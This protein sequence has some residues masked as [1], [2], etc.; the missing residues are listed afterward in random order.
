MSKLSIIDAKQFEKLLFEL[1]FKAVRQKAVTF[2]TDILTGAILF[3]R[4][5]KEE[6]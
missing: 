3:Y 6:I 1:G 4:T 5:I 2:F